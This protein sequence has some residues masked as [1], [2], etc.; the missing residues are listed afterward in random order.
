MLFYVSAN[1]LIVYGIIELIWIV[2]TSASP[3]IVMLLFYY[4][5]YEFKMAKYPAHAIVSIEN[6][7]V[8]KFIHLCDIF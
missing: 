8:T 6:V 5:S 3:I 1:V 4:P 2:H 7:S